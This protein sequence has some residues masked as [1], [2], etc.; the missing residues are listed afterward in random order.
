MIRTIALLILGAVLSRASNYDAFVPACP[1]QASLKFNTGIPNPDPSCPDTHVSLCYTATHLMLD[2]AVLNETNFY[3]DPSQST[4]GDIWEYEVVEAFIYRGLDDPQTYFEYE[5]NANNVT[6][7]AFV[8]NPSRVRK[9]GAPFDHAFIENPFADGFA[10]DTKVYKPEQAW[11]AS[12]AIP[13]ALFNG[14]NPKGSVW[15]M[16]FFRTVTSP[17]TYPDQQLCGWKNTGAANFHIT[18]A[19]GKLKFM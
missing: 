5:V 3:Y 18:G 10:V 7:N 13:L 8:Y 11:Y 15:R 14:E 12:S 9:D 2:F 4:N 16:N 19:F 17:S 6:Y 1:A